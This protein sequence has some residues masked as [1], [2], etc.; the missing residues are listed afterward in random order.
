VSRSLHPGGSP[1][2][3]D[4]ES[5][6]WGPCETSLRSPLGFSV[7]SKFLRIFESSDD[8]VQVITGPLPKSQN[9]SITSPQPS[10]SIALSPHY[11][12]L[13]AELAYQRGFDG[14]L[15]NFESSFSQFEVEQSRALASWITI[16]QSELQARIGPHAQTVWFDISLPEHNDCLFIFVFG[17]GMIASHTMD[18]YSRNRNLTISIF[19]FSSHRLD[20]SQIT[21]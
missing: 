3:I 9:V 12:H 1:P 2:L 7:H 10:G 4:K 6:C 17:A 8:L 15:L 16:L 13:L 20:S 14:Y 18:S 19:H 11:A 5:K 21:K